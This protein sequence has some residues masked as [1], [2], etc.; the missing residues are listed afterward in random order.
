MKFIKKEWFKILISVCLVTITG[1]LIYYLFV[2][3]PEDRD[4]NRSE[5][6]RFECK[7]EIQALYNQ[8]NATASNIEQTEENNQLLFSLA[9]DLGIIDQDGNPVDQSVLIQ[10]CLDG[11]L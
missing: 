10:K 8:Y 1:S 9:L 5:T 6:K 11:E 7:Q 3:L 4:Y 2:F